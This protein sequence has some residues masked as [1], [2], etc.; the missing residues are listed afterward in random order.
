[1]FSSVQQQLSRLNSTSKNK[2]EGMDK[3][4]P[5][6]SFPMAVRARDD[7][8]RAIIIRSR[9]CLRKLQKEDNN[10]FHVS[11]PLA[12]TLSWKQEASLYTYTFPC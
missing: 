6:F 3:S 4:L 10:Q 7:N 9:K 5:L 8:W 2:N 12:F 11:E 1:M